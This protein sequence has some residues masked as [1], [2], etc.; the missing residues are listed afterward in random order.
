[1]SDENVGVSTVVTF[2]AMNEAPPS[3]SRTP[4]NFG[5]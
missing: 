5:R 3:M 4:M 1:M 2:F